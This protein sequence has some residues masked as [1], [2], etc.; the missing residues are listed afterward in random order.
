VYIP[1]PPPVVDGELA[2][3]V[4][5]VRWQI[6]RGRYGSCCICGGTCYT[7]YSPEPPSGYVPLHDGCVGRLID[8]WVTRIADGDFGAE[9]VRTPVSGRRGAYARLSSTIREDPTA[10]VVRV[11]SGAVLPEGFTPGPYWLPGDDHSTPWN[12]LLETAAGQTICP[13]A[14][15]RAH[16]VRVFE[17][18]RANPLVMFGPAIVGGA[19]IAPDGQVV[20][21]WGSVPT[22]G[23]P[24]WSPIRSLSEWQRC[25][26]GELRWPG[27]WVTVD[28]GRCPACRSAEETDDPREWPADPPYPGDRYVPESFVASR[29]VTLPASARLRPTLSR[30]TYTSRRKSG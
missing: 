30:G 21:S 2:V 17:L 11:A 4:H 27:S 10:Q 29:K 22:P 15:N 7:W 6:A 3:N 23:H 9:K 18:Y 14:A 8:H 1:P 25:P 13:A 5:G 20:D 16:A 24:R 12:G 26:C 28:G 19:L